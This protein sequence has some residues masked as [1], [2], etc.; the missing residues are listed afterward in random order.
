M[1]TGKSILVTGGTGSSGKEFTRTVLTRYPDIRRLVIYS[2]DE[3]KQFDR[4]RQFPESEYHPMRYFIGDVRDKERLYRALEG[5][6][7]VVHAAAN[8]KVLFRKDANANFCRYGALGQRKNTGLHPP[9]R[10]GSV[11]LSLG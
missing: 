6:Y 4:S 1:L 5:I 9:D 3:L 10:S 8:W 2:R 7:I 11:R